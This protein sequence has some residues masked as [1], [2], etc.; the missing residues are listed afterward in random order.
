MKRRGWT[1]ILQE[2]RPG[3]RCWPFQ[4]E[5]VL[6]FKE[7]IRPLPALRFK[8][9]KHFWIFIFVVL[10]PLGSYIKYVHPIVLPSLCVG[11]KLTNIMY[12]YL[13]ASI[14]ACFVCKLYY[15]SF[16]LFAEEWC[17][18][19]YQSCWTFRW[20]VL[21]AFLFS[22]K[23]KTIIWHLKLEIVSTWNKVTLYALITFLSLENKNSSCALL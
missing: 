11:L 21:V 16:P 7:T 9:T 23:L 1:K 4:N 3:V 6:L 5:Y 18:S 8:T 15:D 13:L 19:L 17:S 14:L 10:V 22:V 12:T 20:L 2:L